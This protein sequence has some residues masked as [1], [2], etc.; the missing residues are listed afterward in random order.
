MLDLEKI[1]NT[2]TSKIGFFRFKKSDQKGLNLTVPDSIL[3]KFSGEDL[4]K[5]N[6]FSKF[7]EE[8]KKINSLEEYKNWEK[9]YGNELFLGAIIRLKDK[10]S[11]EKYFN[12]GYDYYLEK[13]DP[14][15][16]NEM[17]ELFPG[18]SGIT[19]KC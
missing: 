8:F 11:Y 5:I 19:K 17:K 16:A 7:Y 1:K 2:D 9:T 6:I 15:F 3:S 18:K 4:N 12:Y 10:S 14:D 13:G